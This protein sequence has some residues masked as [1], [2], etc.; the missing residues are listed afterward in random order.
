[1][2]LVEIGLPSISRSHPRQISVTFFSIVAFLSLPPPHSKSTAA[3]HDEAAAVGAGVGGGHWPDYSAWKRFSSAVRSTL[4]G[5]EYAGNS[6]T[7]ARGTKV[8]E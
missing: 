3:I 4:K 5:S 2:T 7:E 6:H 8:I 1:M